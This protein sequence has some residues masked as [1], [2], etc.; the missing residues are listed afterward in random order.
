MLNDFVINYNEI[1][2]KLLCLLYVT[3]CFT[4][5]NSRKI[6]MIFKVKKKICGG[7]HGVVVIIIGNELSYSSSNPE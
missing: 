6:S 3:Y 4:F 5:L 1:I 7:T 2:N